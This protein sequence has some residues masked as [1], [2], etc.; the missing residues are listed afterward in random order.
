VVDAGLLALRR[1]VAVKTAL[2]VRGD[3]S[4]T[5]LPGRRHRQIAD[6]AEA[7]LGD[8]DR[9]AWWAACRKRRR[10]D[11]RRRATWGAVATVLIVAAGLGIASFVKTWSERRAL[12]EQ[13]AR[14]KPEA[15]LA[16]LERGLGTPGIEKGEL[17]SRL[18][19]RP[20]P[21]D[22]LE[23]GMGGVPAERRAASVLDAAELAMP[24]LAEA[25][26]DNARLASLLWALDYAIG[27]TPD[28]PEASRAARIRDSALAPIRRLHPPP[29][30]ADPSWVSV[31]G[32][33]F[34]MG[35]APADDRTGPD[36][37]D[38]YPRH[39]VTVSPFRMLDHEVTV[40]EY[41]RLVAGH[42]GA[43]DFPVTMVTW[44]DAYVYA[45]W[46]GGRLPTETEWEY[47]ARA[48]CEHT[49]C[50][51]GGREARL[52][53]VAWWV[54]NSAAA[55]G[56]QAPHAVRTR[57]PT[58]GGLYDVYGN[59]I[60]WVSDWYG[61]YPDAASVDSKGPVAASLRAARGGS[62]DAPADWTHPSARVAHAPD[63]AFRGL[64]FRPVRAA[65]R[66]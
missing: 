6:C 46:F 64:G 49:Y 22:V 55:G 12:L 54:G 23:S 37:A 34:W 17:L 29:A 39:Q 51:S 45:A 53:E 36:Q 19:L 1:L 38:E 61:P 30:T 32:G 5:D 25:P 35:S 58:Q 2:H 66:D 50:T 10:A 33:R 43:D 57:R 13:V 62:F 16:A 40:A 63:G 21:L 15:A 47:A 8:D 3:A 48:G 27:S 28:T 42:E 20:R 41:R 31:P 26:K 4:A 7:L 9:R 11:L 52:D 44:Y 59:V 56:E 60:E 18:R 65:A 14:G 24:L